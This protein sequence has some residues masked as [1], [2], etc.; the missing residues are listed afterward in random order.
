[1]GPAVFVLCS[2]FALPA[3]ADEPGIITMTGEYVWIS[4][5]GR[6]GPLRAVFTPLEQGHWQLT[7]HYEWHK[8]EKLFKGSA[9]GSLTNGELEGSFDDGHGG[10]YSFKGTL[11]DGQFSGS[12]FHDPK[13]YPRTKSGTLTLSR[14]GKAK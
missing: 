8:E 1:M 10:T 3:L 5:P 13:E 7:I 6:P 4:E 9:R 11:S 12:H 2:F 14:Q